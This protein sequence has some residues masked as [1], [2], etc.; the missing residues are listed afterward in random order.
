MEEEEEEEEKKKKKKKKK[1]EEENNNNN[2]NSND[3]KPEEEMFKRLRT[4]GV[5]WLESDDTYFINSISCRPPVMVWARDRRV[6]PE[7]PS[8]T[9]ICTQR[10]MPK[11]DGRFA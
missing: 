8:G 10:S 1:K 6:H 9:L 5:K 4:L 2:N 7:A 3:N 11:T